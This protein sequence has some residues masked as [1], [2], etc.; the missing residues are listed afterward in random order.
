MKKNYFLFLLLIVSATSSAQLI[1]NEAYFD[2]APFPEGDANGDGEQANLSDDEFLEFVNNSNAPLDISGYKI[3]DKT[4]YDKV[5]ADSSNDSPTHIVPAST[6]LP[7][8]GL[9]VVFGSGDISSFNGLSNVITVTASLGYLSLSNTNDA[10]YVTNPS[11][12]LIIEFDPGALNLNVD[13]D[14]SVARFPALTGDFVAHETINGK[15]FSPGILDVFSKSDLVLNEA[16]YDVASG[17][18]GDANGDGASASAFDDEFLEFV[19]NS[20][21]PLDISGYK[22]YDNNRYDKVLADSSDD[23]PRHIVPNSTIIPAGGIYLVFGGGDVS[24]F[25]SIANLTTHTASSGSLNLTNVSFT[26]IVFVTDAAGELLITFEPG[27]LGLDVNDDQSV[28][29]FL[30]IIGGFRAHQAVNGKSFSPGVLDASITNNLVLNEIFVRPGTNTG[31]ANND[32]NPDYAE[33]EFIEL[34]NNSGAT[35]DMSG[36]KIYDYA[37][38]KTGEANHIV[39][40]GTTIANDGVYVLFGGGNPTGSFGGAIVEVCSNTDVKLSLNHSSVD[41]PEIVII[42]DASDN[43]VSLYNVLDFNQTLNSYMSVTRSP[44]VTGLYVNHM[45][46][47]SGARYSPGTKIDGTKFS[48]ALKIDRFIE[49][50]VNVY[51]TNKNELKITGDLEGKNKLKVFDLLGKVV[52]KNSFNTSNAKTFKI[53]G[54]N[55][56]IYIVNISN[57]LYGNYSKKIILK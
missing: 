7:P 24:G 43:V 33:D 46:L 14:Q 26:D 54:L 47:P 42:T 1:L 55:T 29:R 31:D 41:P 32:G 28:S 22:I 6:I 53:N 56:G 38:F 37:R 15:K 45:D 35:I 44:D 20:S 51:L 12:T 5:V 25:N 16:F 11:G 9:Y 39:P 13:E 30:P 19:N 18:A 34:V 52:Y 48:G 21:S 4:K 23:T 36:Y 8:G 3:Y 57:S 17:L 50:N 49:N 27:A 2:V 10:V 40:N